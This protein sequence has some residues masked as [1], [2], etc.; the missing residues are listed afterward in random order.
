MNSIPLIS[1]CWNGQKWITAD[2]RRLWVFKHLERHGVCE[3]VKVKQTNSIPPWKQTSYNDGTSVKVRGD[4]G[5]LWHKKQPVCLAH[6]AT[7]EANDLPERE[8]SS[9]RPISPRHGIHSSTASLKQSVKQEPIL[10]LIMF[11]DKLLINLNE[12][13][14]EMA[15]E[16]CNLMSEFEREGLEMK[17][18]CE[19]L[20]EKIQIANTF[21]NEKGNALLCYLLTRNQGIMKAGKTDLKRLKL[22]IKEIMQQNLTLLE[23]TEN[24]QNALNQWSIFQI[25]KRGKRNEQQTLTII[26]VAVQKRIDADFVLLGNLVRKNYLMI[27]KGT[28]MLKQLKDDYQTETC[29][30]VEILDEL[31]RLCDAITSRGRSLQRT[32]EI[33]TQNMT[34]KSKSMLSKFATVGQNQIKN[35]TAVVQKI[36]L[37]SRREKGDNLMKTMVKRSK[38]IKDQ[39]TDLS[40]YW[41]A[42]GENL[43]KQGTA[44]FT[45]LKSTSRLLKHRGHRMLA[46]VEMESKN[47]LDQ[48]TVEL[49]MMKKTSKNTI[50]KGNE[51]LAELRKQFYHSDTVHA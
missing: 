38:H 48:G 39:G 26:N 12:M 25:E 36:G 33:A 51:L 32:I 18:K 46:Q 45:Q 41:R 2:N 10:E 15:T 34:E 27:E 35:G 50:L 21:L 40:N 42:V 30:S 28:K 3:R 14:L 8:Y 31:E 16:G 47:L 44:L 24:N 5:G 13:T 1:V 17:R 29:K 11:C 20:N 4:P 7:Y 19:T 6:L 43:E 9:A 37:K 23:D 49:W 22:L